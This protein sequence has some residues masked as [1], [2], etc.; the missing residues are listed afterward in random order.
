MTSTIQAVKAETYITHTNKDLK[1]EHQLDQ[2]FLWVER[3][4]EQQ[5]S[6]SLSYFAK[7]CCLKSKLSL[8]TIL[9]PLL[10]RDY[11][12][13]EYDTKSSSSF[14][15]L[16]SFVTREKRK[17]LEKDL[18]KKKSK[19]DI[20]RIKSAHVQTEQDV[21]NW[22]NR[23][24][25]PSVKTSNRMQ[26]T[27]N[28]QKKNKPISQR[29]TT[30]K[31]NYDI[32]VNPNYTVADEK[33]DEVFVRVNQLVITNELKKPYT[34]PKSL[35]R[36]LFQS[37]SRSTQL[38]R[39]K[40]QLLPDIK[41]PHSHKRLQTAPAVSNNDVFDELSLSLKTAKRHLQHFSPD[42][43]SSPIKS[44]HIRCESTVHTT[45]E[46]K[47]SAAS[48]FEEKF[49]IVFQW[50][51]CWNIKQ[52]EK[53]IK[54][55][56]KLLSPSQIY[57]FYGLLMVRIQSDF[58]DILPHHLS[59]KIFACLKPKELKV[60]CKVSDKWKYLCSNN[61]IWEKICLQKNIALVGF[62]CYMKAYESSK[63][64]EQNW[65]DSKPTTVEMQLHNGSILAIDIFDNLLATGGND[66]IIK[67]WN[68]KK[69]T[70]TPLMMLEG[71][72]KR[73]WDLKFLSKLLL[74]SC[75]GDNTIK[76]WNLQSYSCV[77]T[78]CGHDNAVWC[79][80]LHGGD[81]L[82]SG[83][84]DRT[85]KQWNLRNCKIIAS[86]TP[87]PGG[88]YAIA[89]NDEGTLLFTGTVDRSIRLWNIESQFCIETW[90]VDCSK[91]CP[92]DSLSYS[93][94]YLL[95]CCNSSFYLWNSNKFKDRP[96]K[97][98]SDAHK[99]KISSVVLTMK[100]LRESDSLRER[101]DENIEGR[102]ITASKDGK[103]KVWSL[104]STHAVQNLNCIG[105]INVIKSD[106]TQVIAGLLDGSMKSFAFD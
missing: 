68:F 70:E 56:M 31:E 58:V 51:N 77:R 84:A 64:I 18:K 59:I 7:Q 91:S 30:K 60:C 106:R 89:V 63:V 19:Q 13:H 21:C 26:A 4:N 67:V 44:C 24:I 53:F 12:Y 61:K 82:F 46:T 5:I 80:H 9:E 3:W 15:S 1:Y 39:C 65:N 96:I 66:K 8:R 32:W 98:Y 23:S 35:S 33:P 102:V 41:H 28:K 79:L 17:K 69:L 54:L 48:Y 20:Y 10:H 45:K 74:I 94:G 55:F 71:H 105:G 93:Q 75:S 6:R 57:Y 34:A 36:D 49:V 92:V 29:I 87:N 16:S 40:T 72:T 95:S 50:F 90:Q 76:F 99:E 81:V 85:V 97:T 43:L 104:G 25:L 88:I 83:S 101:C 62:T 11:I 52:Q 37:P 100:T 78:L 38:R 22:S 14:K 47:K 27:C 73:I 2:V 86:F 42:N 103:V